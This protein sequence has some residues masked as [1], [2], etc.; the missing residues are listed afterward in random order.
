MNLIQTIWHFIVVSLFRLI[1]LF[2]LF[3]QKCT[4]NLVYLI[5]RYI[6]RYRRKV[7][8]NNLRNSFPEKT[9]AETSQ[10]ANAYYRHIAFMMI[11]N[12]VLRH[13]SKMKIIDCLNFINGDIIKKLRDKNKNLLI[14]LGHLGNWE[15]GSVIS[16]SFGYKGAAIYQK[17]SSP[18]FDRIYYD[19]RS[20]LGVIPIEMHHVLRQVIEL[21]KQD[22]P[23]ILFSVADQAPS[24]SESNYWLRFLNQETDV[25]MGPEK[26][27]V[28]F[29]MPIVYCEIYRT[30]FQR[31]DV[32]FELITDHPKETK[33]HEIIEN[34][35]SHLEKSITKRPENWLWSHKRW[36]HKERYHGKKL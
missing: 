30:G 19:L 6:I 27:S 28:K 18:V 13:T 2:P 24:F 14:V 33:D 1:G 21:N 4:G 7:I 32:R 17:L 8:L 23:F 3:L 11:E 29:D 26:I 12:M 35:Y 10:I 25:F 15:Y 20:N 34:F 16:T 22:E 36:K 31:F 9:S 5:V